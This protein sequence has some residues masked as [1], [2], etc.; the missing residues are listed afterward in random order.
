MPHWIPAGG[1]LRILLKFSFAAQ[2]LAGAIGL[3]EANVKHA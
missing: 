2:S 1:Y 3:R